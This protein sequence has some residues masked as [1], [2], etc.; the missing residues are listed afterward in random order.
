MDF[1]VIVII[2][3]NELFVYFIFY[4]FKLGFCIY[5]Y[6]CLSAV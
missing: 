5:T 1:N 2:I 4:F 6:I 3:T